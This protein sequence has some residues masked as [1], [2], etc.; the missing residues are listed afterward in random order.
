MSEENVE[1]A[2]A[3]FDAYSARDVEAVDRLLDPDAEITT[4]TE[5]PGC[6]RAGVGEQRGSISSSSTKRT[7]VH[8]VEVTVAIF[9][10]E[11]DRL[12][13]LPLLP[14]RNPDLDDVAHDAKADQGERDRRGATKDVCE[15]GNRDHAAT[16]SRQPDASLGTHSGQALRFAVPP[17]QRRCQLAGSF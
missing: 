10:N 17:S 8:V 4:L 5:E 13:A 15:V 9:V 6:Q 12:R 14:D 16:V 3:S 1:L 11:H 2:T 7:A